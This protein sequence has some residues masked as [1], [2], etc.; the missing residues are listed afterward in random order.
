MGIRRNEK[1]FLCLLSFSSFLLCLFRLFRLFY[2][3]FFV[4]VLSDPS[5]F[6]E[7]LDGD[8]ALFTGQ[9]H[10]FIFNSP[11]G[12]CFGAHGRRSNRFACDVL[13]LCDE[14]GLTEGPQHIEVIAVVFAV[15]VYFLQHIV[16][17][18]TNGGRV[19]LFFIRNFVAWNRYGFGHRE[20]TCY[21][22]CIRGCFNL[23]VS[24]SIFLK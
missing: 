19:L 8:N 7:G 1:R 2:F 20:C 16:I 11:V 10:V 15:Y 17:L 21:T 14:I 5:V 12:G 4:L 13:T 3:V 18:H 9:P 22:C 24:V 23:V 6:Y